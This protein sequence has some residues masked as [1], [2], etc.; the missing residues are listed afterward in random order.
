MNNSSKEVK[1]LAIDVVKIELNF[2]QLFILRLA[3]LARVPEKQ[4]QIRKTL[5]DILEFIILCYVCKFHFDFKK[6]LV[7]RD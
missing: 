6:V 3:R 1:V 5:V 2:G 7:S 4:L